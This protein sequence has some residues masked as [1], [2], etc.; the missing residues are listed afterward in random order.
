MTHTR[1]PQW[2]LSKK[3]SIRVALVAMFLLVACQIP[4]FGQAKLPDDGPPVPTSQAAAREF[5]EKVTDAG[6]EGAKTGQFKLTVT[7][8]Q[9]TSFLR[10]GAEIAEQLRAA[11]NLENL[12][13]LAQLQDLEGLEEIEELA[14]WQ[15]LARRREGLPKIRLPDLSLRLGIQEPEVRFQADGQIV[16][17]GYGQVRSLRQPLRVVVAARAQDGELVFDFVEGSLGPVALPEGL[18]DLIGRGL[19]SAI[20]IGQEYAEVTQI[21]VSDG[22]LTLSGRYNK[23]QLGSIG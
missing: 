11:K 17:R 23:E 12:E 14:K 13:D 21:E 4:R 20:L 19:A 3:L 22:T 1:R 15:E 5:V 9:V 2:P 18:F 8:E 6:L 10:I 7:Q 16:V